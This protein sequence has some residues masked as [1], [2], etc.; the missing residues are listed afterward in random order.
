MYMCIDQQKILPSLKIL[1]Q[2]SRDEK[3]ETRNNDGNVTGGHVCV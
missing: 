3:H 1:A 2:F